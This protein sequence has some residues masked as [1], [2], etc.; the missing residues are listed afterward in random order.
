MSWPIAQPVS[1]Q[2]G[3]EH[4]SDKSPQKAQTL[5]AQLPAP[6]FPLPWSA[7]VRLLSLTSEQARKFYETEALRSGWS[8]PQLESLQAL[9]K[10]TLRK[11]M[12]AQIRVND[13]E[14]NTSEV[15]TGT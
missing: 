12:T 15:G 9:F 4:R 2:S 10:T 3:T 11:L 5:S 7:Y 6:R 8:V 13:L 14:I 1:A